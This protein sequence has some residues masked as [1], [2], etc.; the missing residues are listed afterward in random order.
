MKKEHQ[1]NKL[2]KNQSIILKVKRLILVF[3]QLI[4]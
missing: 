1:V 3:E 2:L 4:L